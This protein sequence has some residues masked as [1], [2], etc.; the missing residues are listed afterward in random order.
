MVKAKIPEKSDKTDPESGFWNVTP[1]KRGHKIRLPGHAPC[2]ISTEISGQYLGHELYNVSSC[3]CTQTPPTPP[4]WALGSL[5][6][7]TQNEGCPSKHL[8]SMLIGKKSK[9]RD[10]G[11]NWK[12]VGNPQIMSVHQCSSVL[13]LALPTRS[14][15]SLVSWQH[16]FKT[17]HSA[18]VRVMIPLY[19]DRVSVSLE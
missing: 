14:S 13:A 1:I 10:P 17:R 7:S 3:P 2:Y 15:I 8:E 19:G 9:I 16:V 4:W 5:Q 18:W 11:K 12:K 6:Q